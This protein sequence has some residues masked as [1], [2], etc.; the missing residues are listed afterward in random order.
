MRGRT[1]LLT[2]ILLFFLLSILKARAQ[3]VHDVAVFDATLEI[4]YGAKSVYGGHEWVYWWVK[5]HATVGNK[6]DFEESFNVTAYYDSAVTGSQQILNLAAGANAT[7]TFTWFTSGVTPT[8]KPYTIK[9]VADTVPEET[10]TWDNTFI[11]ASVLVKMPGDVNGD[12][13]VNYR[14]VFPFAVCY[15]SIYPNPL[16]DLRADFNGDGR[17]NYKDLALFAIHYGRTYA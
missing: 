5:V 2:F 8:L 16:Y 4:P 6:G 15:G 9:V 1:L 3:G 12:G 13:K 14:D 7:L 11:D 10:F 17:V